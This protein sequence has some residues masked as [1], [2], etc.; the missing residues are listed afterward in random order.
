M[1]SGEKTPTVKDFSNILIFRRASLRTKNSHGANVEFNIREIG[2]KF[3]I[4]FLHYL[5]STVIDFT[6]RCS[7]ARVVSMQSFIFV[8]EKVT[9]LERFKL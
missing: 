4:I 8:S 5:S 7:L 3:K 9:D 6:W 2:R 1:P